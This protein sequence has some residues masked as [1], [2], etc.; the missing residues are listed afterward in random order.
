[1]PLYLVRWPTFVASIV[2]ANDEDH[3]TDILDE[4]ASPTEAVWTEYDGPLWVD[5]A[6]GIDA[7]HEEG[8]WKLSGIEHAA[9]APSLGAELR[10]EDC[11]T[12]GEMFDAVLAKAFPHLAKLLDSSQEADALDPAEVRSAALLDLWLHRPSG[13]L[14]AWLRKMFK[15]RGGNGAP[16]A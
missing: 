13:D 6:L 9:S 2:R 3:L 10:S 7:Q 11:D 4:V 16:K 15:R 1:M 8:E 12:S 5:F 14:P